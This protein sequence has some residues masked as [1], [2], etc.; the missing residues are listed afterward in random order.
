MKDALTITITF[1][2]SSP[3]PAHDGLSSGHSVLGHSNA[4]V[5]G[6]RETDVTP[7]EYS[8]ESRR[9]HADRGRTWVS[10]GSCAVKKNDKFKM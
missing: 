10:I 1:M 7:G 8:K 4:V 9:S 5:Q 6:S 2:I 3:D